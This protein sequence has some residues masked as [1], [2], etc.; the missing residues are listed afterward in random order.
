MKSI[1]KPAVN[2]QYCRNR[3]SVK[4]TNLSKI[5]VNLQY[6]LKIVRKSKEI[7]LDVIVV[8]ESIKVHHQK[9][10]KKKQPK[11]K[12]KRR[13]KKRDVIVKNLKNHT[14]KALSKR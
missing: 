8:Q 4:E 7:K 3:V 1:V 10:T 12:R 5:V 13:S 14:P 9:P 2:H 6:Y 11:K